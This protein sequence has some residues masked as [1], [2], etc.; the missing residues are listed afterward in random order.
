MSEVLNAGLV[1][2]EGGRAQAPLILA[3][4]SL[5]TWNGSLGAHPC[6]LVRPVASLHSLPD[7]QGLKSA[8]V[9][10]CL[11]SCALEQLVH[12]QL[13]PAVQ[14]MAPVGTGIP[15]ALG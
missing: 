8:R 5:C 3:Q 14:P 15:G 1:Q 11:Q 9:P 4:I 10:W 13:Q 7:V 6:C 2:G 12:M